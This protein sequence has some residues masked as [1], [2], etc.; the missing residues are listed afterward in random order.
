MSIVV[1]KRKATDCQRHH[2][3]NTHIG[4][5]RNQ[6]PTHLLVSIDN[7]STTLSIWVHNLVWAQ[8]HYS[9]HI[10]I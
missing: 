10:K 6:L 8:Q 5:Q 1:F 2:G 9:V 4:E 7:K 3:E